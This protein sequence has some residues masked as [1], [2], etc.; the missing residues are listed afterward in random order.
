MW[1]P[2]SPCWASSGAWTTRRCE[3][4][5][6]GH[7]ARKGRTPGRVPPPSLHPTFDADL[8]LLPPPQG[9]DLIRDN[10]D[11]LMSERVQLVLLGSG[12]EDLEQAL[13]DMENKWVGL[14]STLR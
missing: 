3:G 9:V 5:A 2:T 14:R 13:R 11:W 10:Y 4:A 6:W 1:T 12:R 8:L 7:R